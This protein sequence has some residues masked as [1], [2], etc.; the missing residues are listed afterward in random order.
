MEPDWLEAELEPD[1]L[2]SESLSSSGGDAGAV[3][4]VGLGLKGLEI[5]SKPKLNTGPVSQLAKALL[6]LRCDLRMR[7]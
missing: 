5:H 2:E 1:W 3:L 6:S 7:L 4:T